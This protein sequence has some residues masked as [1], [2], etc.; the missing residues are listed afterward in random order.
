MRPK[1]IGRIYVCLF[2]YSNDSIR[3]EYTNRVH[4]PLRK[5]SVSSSSTDSVDQFTS[6]TMRHY[7][8]VTIVL[9][10]N[11]GQSVF[12]KQIVEK[13]PAARYEPT[14]PSLD[15]RSLPPWYD[16]AK[17][18]IFVHWG[19]YAV[20]AFGSEWFWTN[21]KNAK[22]PA[23]EQFM[24]TNYRP[25]FTYQEFAADFRAEL[26][27]ASAWTELFAQS[28]AKYV[29][30]TSKHHD[31]YALWPSKYSFSWNSVDVGPHRDL[32]GELYT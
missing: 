15:S 32:V 28:G 26:F 1:T 27:N 22:A 17:V 31:G 24:N 7:W 21:W 6:H 23:Y 2:V 25:G 16:N 20:P 29:V 9:L 5:I 13:H 19:V 18:G 4:L 8:L 30:L 11:C 12:A 10:A 14:W 3:S